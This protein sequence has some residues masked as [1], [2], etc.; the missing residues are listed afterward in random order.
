MSRQEAFGTTAQSRGGSIRTK[1]ALTCMIFLLLIVGMGLFAV[2]QNEAVGEATR[3]VRN[4]ALPKIQAMHRVERA[5][6]THQLLVK[7]RFQTTDFRQLAAIEQ[8]M[9]EAQAVF[10]SHV[11][12]LRLDARADGDQRMI[13]NVMLHWDR[14]LQ[15]AE[16]VNRLTEQG[17]LREARTKLHIDTETAASDLFAALDR[18]IA[19]VQMEVDLLSA[20][21]EQAYLRARSLSLGAVF[22]GFVAT[23]IATIWIGRGVS[24]PLLKI[25]S[26]MHRLM[27]GHHETR[28]PD[29]THRDDEI[30]VLARA[31]TAFRGSIIETRALAVEVDSERSRLEATVQNMPL[32]LCMFDTSGALMVSNDAFRKL[33]E[34]DATFPT[35][36]ADQEAVLAMIGELRAFEDVDEFV[37][38]TLKV[39]S[40]GF[41]DSTVWH[42]LDGRSVSAILQPTPD[43]W[44]LICEDITDRVAAEERI[45]RLARN[46]ALTGLANRFSFQE[47]IERALTSAE[48]KHPTAVMFIDLDR[49][50][51]VNDTMGHPAGDELLRQV[52]GRLAWTAGEQDTV[53]RLGGDEFAVIQRNKDSQPEAAMALGQDIIEQLTSPFI[54]EGQTVHIGGSVGV[55]L[56]PQ[57]G[58]TVEEIQKNADIALYAVKEQG[59][60]HCQVFNAAMQE[61]QNAMHLLEQALRR[62]L[63]LDQFVVYYQPLF[64]VKTN[65]AY[66][67]EALVRWVH[68]TRGLVHPTEFVPMAEELGLIQQLGKTVLH[69]TCRAAAHWP[70][71]TKLSVNLSPVQFHR[72]DVYGD[73]MGALEPSGL[74]PSRLELE[75]TEGVLLEHTEKTFEILHAFRNH[76]IRIALDD[77]G[78]GYSSLRYLRTFPFDRVKIDASFIRGLPDDQGAVAIV[79]AISSLCRTFDIQLTAEG[80][81]TEA[82]LEFVRNSGCSAGQGYHLAHPMPEEAFLEFL[83]QPTRGTSRAVGG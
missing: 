76:G 58:T 4:V 69:K 18:L 33:F 54:I 73:V 20:A 7:R 50:K 62:A 49:F 12:Q 36:G 48:Q 70:N 9:R 23:L 74:D 78:T 8:E 53:A 3:D 65:S 77:F 24:N 34:L 61:K 10:T 29:L 25:S 66:G 60:G 82:Q 44:M 27:D 52:A 81:E 32:A 16:E 75:I 57:H 45:R 47:E 28:I 59:K 56:A 72:H 1:L 51:N 6:T 26:A 39:A 17:A 46:D 43:G 35:S 42:L 71:D 13:E 68:P 31:A 80:I 83:G 41:A 40:I 11:T 37:K 38:A 22:L 2:H 79:E 21:V 67:A 64:D 63:D 15:A 19:N 14:Y 5:L 30:G 55:A